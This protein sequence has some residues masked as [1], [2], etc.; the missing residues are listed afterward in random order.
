MNGSQ[1]SPALTVPGLL[2]SLAQTHPAEVALRHK[3]YGLWNEVSYAG[4]LEQVQITALGLSALGMGRGERVAIICENTPLWLYAQLGVQAA[5][6]VSVGIYPSMTTRE[7]AEVLA[8][9]GAAWAIVQGE[10][11]VDKLLELQAVHPLRRV[12]YGQGRGMRKHAG[13]GLLLTFEALGQLGREGHTGGFGALLTQ[14]GP[15]DLV[16]LTLSSGTTR[17]GSG[18]GAQENGEPTERGDPAGT[19]GRAVTVTHRQL[20]SLGCALLEVDPLRPGDD[21]LSFL[22]LAWSGEQIMSVSVALQSRL[23]VNF[24][25]SSETVMTDLAELGPHV[26]YTPPRLWEDLRTA[27]LRRVG[28]SYRLNRAVSGALLRDSMRA[29]GARLGGQAPGTAGGFFSRHVAGLVLTRPMLDRSGLL[30]LRRAYVTGSA[31]SPELISFF[32]ALGVNLK[33]A[34]GQAESLGLSHVHR[35]GEVQSGTVGQ[36][37]PGAETRLTDSGEL[38]LRAPWQSG[39]YFNDDAASAARWQQ[40]W[41]HSGDVGQVS[42]S[43]GQ[44]EHLIVR[45]RADELCRTLGGQVVEPQRSENRLKLSPYIREAL[46]L[47]EGQDAPTALLAL[48]ADAVG[49]WAEGQRLAYSTFAD[50][51]QRPEVAALIRAEVQAANCDLSSEQQVRRFALLY[52]PLD[53]DDGELTRTGTVRRSV[54]LSRFAPLIAGLKCGDS[55]VALSAQVEYGDGQTTAQDMTITL[56]HLDAASVPDHS[57]APAARSFA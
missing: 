31:L 7:I 49:G 3:Q 30:R 54:M 48:D 41:L 21:Y 10:E 8:L 17:G 44:G 38:L 18:S 45:G 13:N 2:A 50:L 52:K 19:T 9:T 39:G 56:H 16:H 47:A 25:E 32:H 5:G 11:Q 35:D 36:P 29:A 4:Y 23:T 55:R 51:S 33:A 22:P 42:S 1:G 43:P 6:G 27:L 40:G 53:A 20:L 57:A 37:L 24:P 15:D 14:C 34:Y 12:V 26:M 28:A 46:V